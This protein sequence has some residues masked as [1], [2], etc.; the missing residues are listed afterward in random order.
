MQGVTNALPFRL[1]VVRKDISVPL[2]PMNTFSFFIR[3]VQVIFSSFSSTSFQNFLS[4]SDL[5]PEV[6]KFQHHK[7]L[8]SKLRSNLINQIEN[9]GPSVENRR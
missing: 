2:E 5:I 7:K 3:S 9:A 8:C 1:F 4:I 6:S